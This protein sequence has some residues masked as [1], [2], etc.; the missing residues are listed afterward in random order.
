MPC[1]AERLGELVAAERPAV[2]VCDEMD[3]GAVV[4]AESAGIP[5]VTVAVLAA[6]RL[7]GPDVIAAAWERLRADHGL[8]VDPDGARFAGTVRVTPM[9][10][11]LRDRSVVTPFDPHHVRPAILDEIARPAGGR[12][13][14]DLV[15]ATLG[16]VFDVESG[17]LFARLVRALSSLDTEALLTIG[18]HVGRDELPAA[19]PHVRI[20]S[21]VPQRDVLTRCRAVV[22]HGGTGTV[23]AALSLG[24]PLVILPMGADQSDNADRCQDLGTGIVLDASDA[25]PAAI[26]A[27]IGAVLNDD[28]YRSAASQIAAEAA[29]Q[30]HLVDVAD[31]ADIL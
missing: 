31:V 20:E 2:V 26:A 19:A 29:T 17:D 18:P 28:R 4:A 1:R 6:G 22:C 7:S 8:P 5:C 24:V 3:A 30:P 23:V 21:F 14:A 11:S 13:D 27:A 15:Y 9:P 10:A 16:T 25:E 12:I